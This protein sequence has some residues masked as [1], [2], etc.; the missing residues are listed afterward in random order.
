[1]F[2][3]KMSIA[4]RSAL[5]LAAVA[6]AMSTGLAFGQEETSEALEEVIVTGSLIKRVDGFESASPVVVST[7]AEISASGISKVEDF[8]NSLPQLSAGQNSYVSNGASGTA[9]LDLRGMGSSRTLVLI[10][11]RRMGGGGAYGESADT[12]QIPTAMLERVEVL[13]GG[14]STVYGADAV[15]GVV[16]FVMRK[17]FDGV[18][19]NIG[20]SGFMHDNDNSYVAG[21][22]DA[23]GFDYPKGGDGVDGQA[24]TIDLVMGSSFADGKGQATAYVTWRKGSELRQGARDYS[25]C[26]LNSTGTSCGGSGNAIV[27]NFYISQRNAAGTLD[28]DTYEYW[29][30]DSG[31]N[32][33]PSDGN[34][35]NYAPINHFM[36]PDEKWSFGTMMDLQLN[37]STELYAEIMATDYNTKAQIAES[38][39]FFAEEY[40]IDYD[41]ALLN[42]SQR[43][44][45][46]DTWGLASGDD[47]AVY[48]GK[49]N[50]EGG[51]RASVMTNASFRIVLGARGEVQGWDYDVNYQKNSVDS[52]V[53]Y[54]NDFF[55]PNISAALQAAT[56]DVFTYQGVTSEQASGLTGTAM[57]R[58]DLSTEIFYAQMSRDTG[59]SL[60]T[61]DSNISV[62]MG[63]EN[64]KMSYD[65]D[66]DTVFEEGQLLGQGGAT[67]SIAGSFSVTDVFL[68]AAIP[69]IENLDM[70]LGFRSSD[71]STSGNHNT[72]KVGATYS[73]SEMV[74]L[75]TGYNR[76]IRSP[77]ITTMF[78][79]QNQGL[80][81]GSDPCAGDAPTYTAAQCALTGVTAAQYGNI[82]ASPAS[83]YNALYGGNTE[84]D[85]ETAD[86][87]S[88]GIVANPVEDLTLSVDW[89]SVALED[90]IGSVAASTSIKECAENG[91]TALCSLINRGNAGTLWLGTSG[92]VTSTSTNLGE[93]NFAGVDVAATYGMALGGGD[94]SLKL[95]GSKSLE[96]EVL[97]L[98]GVETTR[99]D[100]NGIAND[101]QCTGPNM[102][103]RHTLTANYS[104][105][106]W[107]VGAAWRYFGKVDYKG[108]ADT[109]A[110]AGALDAVN[111]IDLNGSY[112]LNENVSF[113]AG[114]RNLLDK[115]TP[116]V[117]G[118]L[119]PDNA[120]SYGN[121][122]VLGRYIYADVTI[123]F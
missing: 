38:G 53:T 4:V 9:T 101:D 94:L 52:S 18:E 99:Y 41:S 90:A 29:T 116:M 105:D 65:R 112:T 88:F 55:A 10:N 72:Y 26:A 95:M 69:V 78:A 37:D 63:V 8:L 64:R 11:G 62:A 16:N 60:P 102:D 122:D 39:T 12:N 85:P 48:I 68:E 113:S 117:G 79:P 106:D 92:Y 80:W 114:A 30:L 84:L 27:P 67:K 123:S 34:I 57:L 96:K 24:D 75:R 59:F 119:N 47:F 76:T 118:G 104:K 17:D 103:W 6:S 93:V 56:Y 15:A 45:L 28:W 31:S 97:V 19:L 61:T 49:R 107:T 33:V 1:M 81:A 20:T 50:V 22:M 77:N 2:N 44:A 14:A 89:W 32:F 66:S 121:Y 36:R 91:N 42:D 86:T 40:Y 115:E 21:L 74:T 70:E 111:Y 13:T 71:Y 25:S 46:T 54:I 51:P 5:G 3:K 35:Y 83:Q 23:K 109:L 58:A 120:N 100:C 82:V 73:P 108:T 98:P 43:T 110:A 87:I 7:A